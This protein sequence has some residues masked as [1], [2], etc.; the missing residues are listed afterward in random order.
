MQSA[1]L[2]DTKHLREFSFQRVFIF[3][4]LCLDDSESACFK[5]SILTFS[6]TSRG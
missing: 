3:N 2:G 6:H 4:P 5:N 1:G